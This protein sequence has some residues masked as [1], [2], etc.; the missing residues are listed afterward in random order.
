MAPGAR[1]ATVTRLAAGDVYVEL[2][3][4]AR[5]FEFGPCRTVVADLAVGDRVLVIPMARD[6]D[7]LAVLGRIL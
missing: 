4:V 2:P 1:T 7:E 6:A 3:D 5:G